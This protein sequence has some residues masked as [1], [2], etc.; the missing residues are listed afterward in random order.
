MSGS[1]P[2]AEPNTD[3]PI[4]AMKTECALQHPLRDD[5]DMAEHMGDDDVH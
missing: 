3:P 5:V 1:V 4:F 2:G